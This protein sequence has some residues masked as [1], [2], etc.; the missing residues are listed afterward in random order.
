MPWDRSFAVKGCGRRRSHLRNSASIF[1]ADSSSQIFWSRVLARQDA[2]VECFVPDP[3]PFQ[4]AFRVLVPVD[5]ELRVVGKIRAKLQE[6]RAEVTVNRVEVVLV[7]H[8]RRAVEPCVRGARVGVPPSSCS[9]DRRLLL[10]LAHEEDPL[11]AAKALPILRG[12]VVL[13][14]FLLERETFHLPRTA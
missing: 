7:H 10:R 5:T 6:E 13:T 8:R 2:V 4:L 1:S 11:L 9:E 3:P 12:H 14:L